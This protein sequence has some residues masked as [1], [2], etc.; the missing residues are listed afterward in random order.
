MSYCWVA[1]LAAAAMTAYGLEANRE[2][3]VDAGGV[4][5]WT[6]DASEVALLGVN[7]YTPFT[8]DYAELCRLGLDP[9]QSLR[10]DVAHLRRLGLDCLRVHCFDRQISDAEGN[11]LDNEHLALLDFLIDECRRNGLYTVLTPIAWWGAGRGTAPTAGF[12]DRYDIRQMTTDP[13]AWAVQARFLKQFAEHVNRYTGR[14][15]AA[16]PCVLAFE[17]INEPL[18]PKATPDR[19]VTAYINALADALRAGGTRQP[20]FYNSWQGRNA[21]A[22]A[23]R[24]DGVTCSSYPTGLVAG[25]A[26][27]GPQTGRVK[28]S[29]LQPDDSLRTKASL[30]Y[31]FDAADVPG[32]HM[33]PL[34]AKMFRSEGVQVAAQFQYDLLAL[35]GENRNWQTHH[36]NLVYTPGKALSLAIAAEVFRRVPRGVPYGKLPQ[37]AAFPPFRVSGAEDLSELMTSDCFL[38]SNATKTQPPNAAALTRVW[39]CGGSPV[40]AYEGSGAYFL[41]RVVAGVWRVQLYPDVFVLAD[42]Y[43]GT[44]GVKVRALPGTHPFRVRLPDLGDAPEVCELSGAG[45]IPLTTLAPG[46]YLLVRRGLSLSDAVLKQAQG[47]APRYVSPALTPPEQPLV[48]GHLPRQALAG[49]PLTV[50]ADAADGQS[51][52][53]TVTARL[54][55]QAAPQEAIVLPLARRGLFRFSGEVPAGA[56]GQGVWQV[57]V[58]ARSAPE[59]VSFAP[60]QSVRCVGTQEGWSL[61]DTE[62]WLRARHDGGALRRARAVDSEG[63]TALH[64][65]VPRFDDARDSTSYRVPCSG[66]PAAFGSAGAVLLVRARAAQPKTTRLELVL[67]QDDGMPWGTVIPLTPEWKTI[68]IPVSELHFFKH[69]GAWPELKAG[70]QLTL[71]KIAAVNLCF[72]RW[73]YPG[74]AGEPHAFE[75]SEIAIINGQSH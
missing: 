60:C 51:G 44:D 15:M 61:F 53:L 55:R 58:E 69:W 54:V 14:R 43:T 72:G 74:A 63:R 48:R 10:D 16:E 40:V 42:P 37:A 52:A 67:I 29:S 21:A 49:N 8:I 71:S 3:R 25:R 23:A 22:G 66:V 9:R 7:L 13:Q 19:V 34:M 64:A 5:R 65:S 39:G 12:S 20:L 6:D 56:L 38:Y 1:A 32:S 59:R 57:T 45:R 17:C 24:I 26:L 70:E 18:Y 41:D 4:L 36:L 27:E 11:L 2:A 47:A 62:E 31:E 33:Y 28:G 30:A 73:L 75:I 46:D 68:R 50:E 35:A